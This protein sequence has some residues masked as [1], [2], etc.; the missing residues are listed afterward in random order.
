MST[1]QIEELNQK[2]QTLKEQKSQ[3]NVEASEWAEK[4]N[5]LNEKVKKLRAEINEIKS[6]RDKLNKN[7]KKLKQQRENLQKEIVE[8]IEEI[9]RL[10]QELPHARYDHSQF[11]LILLPFQ[12]KQLPLLIKELDLIIHLLKYAS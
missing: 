10:R 6:E 4:R 2:L 9:K 12:P 11:F 8:K 7:V 1:R 5:K 3:L